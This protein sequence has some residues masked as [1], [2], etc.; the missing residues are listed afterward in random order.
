MY[1]FFT[2]EEIANFTCFS[3][4]NIL[5]MNDFQRFCVLVSVNAFY[6]FFLF[7]VITLIYKTFLKIINFIF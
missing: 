1:L 7:F 6:L 5:L 4:F 3:S 2:L